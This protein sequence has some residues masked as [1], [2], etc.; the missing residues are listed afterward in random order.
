M[1]ILFI[2]KTNGNDSQD[3]VKVKDV[4][5]CLG[6]LVSLNILTVRQ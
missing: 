4:V 6:Q 5:F 2:V 1:I 3:T